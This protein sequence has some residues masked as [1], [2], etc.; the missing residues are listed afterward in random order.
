MRIAG[1]S[2]YLKFKNRID[3]KE[4][5]K[6]FKFERKEGDVKEVDYRAIRTQIESLRKSK[7]KFKNARDKLIFFLLAEAGL[8]VSEMLSLSLKNFDLENKRLRFWHQKQKAEGSAEIT[9]NIKSALEDQLKHYAVKDKLFDLSRQ[10]VDQILKSYFHKFS[11]HKLRHY[12]IT[13]SE[14]RNSINLKKKVDIIKFGELCLNS[15][16]LARKMG[17]NNPVGNVVDYF[18]PTNLTE[19]M[20]Q[21]FIILC[22]SRK[23]KV[24]TLENFIKKYS[25]EKRDR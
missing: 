19:E 15:I 11:A 12:F 10:T 21:D 1:L 7:D 3:L 17:R 14:K 20:F 4:Y 25:K 8:R 18:H 24:N 22:S 16:V 9:T 2:A 6:E 13:K 5:L 23:K